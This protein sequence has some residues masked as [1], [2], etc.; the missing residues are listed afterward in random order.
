MTCRI[1]DMWSPWKSP[2][3]PK[4][5][6]TQRLITTGVVVHACNSSTQKAKA[7]FK[8]WCQAGMHRVPS[9]PK[10]HS[11]ILSKEHK[12]TNRQAKSQI[13]SKQTKHQGC[14]SIEEHLLLWVRYLKKLK[15][16]FSIWPR[17]SLLDNCPTRNVK[18][19]ADEKTCI[20]CL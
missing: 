19:S 13:K 12:Q 7:V 15:H 3:A 10:L 8:F 9:K 17:N 14:S 2:L 4:V 18:I 20:K 5:V 11:K 16:K 6:A 1:S